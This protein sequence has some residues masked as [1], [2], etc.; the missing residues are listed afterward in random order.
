MRRQKLLAPL[1][2]FAATLA[3]ALVSAQEQDV[4]AAAQDAPVKEHAQPPDEKLTADEEREAHDLALKFSERLREAGGDV[5]P[6]IPEFFVGDFE[7][8]LR[9]EGLGGGSE[10][11]PFSF[12]AREVLAKASGQELRRFYVTALQAFNVAFYQVGPRYW[13]AAEV[14]STPDVADAYPPELAEIV[15]RDPTFIALRAEWERREAAKEADAERRAAN[16]EP[17]PESDRGL[18]TTVA[19]LNGV[20][21]LG[22][23]VLE[24]M[25][26]YLATHPAPPEL[27]GEEEGEPHTHEP[28]LF[29]TGKESYGLPAGARL[30]RV[31][32]FPYLGMNY[33]LTLVRVNGG[34]KILSA[35]PRLDDDG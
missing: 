7:E 26:L 10:D 25:K 6:L 21:G 4:T 11:F 31:E 2:V 34:L 27:S 17:E 23:K 18:I 5:E 20:T 8:R 35:I 14:Q 9:D 32:T 30:I 22:E 3:P 33:R 24:W 15:Q 29:V 12:V 19:Q 1:L 13:A 28:E 16:E